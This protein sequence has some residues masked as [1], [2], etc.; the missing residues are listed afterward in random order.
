M[1][2][3]LGKVVHVALRSRINV[4]RNDI[5]RSAAKN[6]SL[7]SNA[8]AISDLMEMQPR[9]LIGEGNA[10]SVSSIQDNLAN[11][12]QKFRYELVSREQERKLP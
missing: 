4:G 6:P 3:Q 11:G 2:D 12:L 5:E 1:L 10:S 9:L 7:A 8:G